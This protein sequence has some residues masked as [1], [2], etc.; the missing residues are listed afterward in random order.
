M[1]VVAHARVLAFLAAA[2]FLPPPARTIAQEQRP[3]DWEQ[4]DAW[5]HPE[6]VMDALG[7][8][9]GSAVADVGCG[10][11]YFTFHL[12]A[13]VGP[14]GKVYAEDIDW[15]RVRDLDMRLHK[16]PLPQVQTLLGKPDDPHLPAESIDVILIVDT[17][18]EMDKHEAMLQAMFQALK[19]GGLLGIIDRAGK[20]G[21]PRS[22][23]HKEHHIPPELVQD[24]VTG[25]GFQFLRR[26]FTP[27]PPDS[28]LK[29]FFL[30]FQKPEEQPIG[31]SQ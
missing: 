17:Y 31:K 26:E 11:G 6:A 7:V 30:V 22:S 29:Y 1:R 8:K 10:E 9:P 28:S 2:T 16:D 25:S 13:R 24:E 21:Q 12:A 14:Q 5:Q 15:K 4:R 27:S 3:R 23:Y 20:P 19:P 18:H